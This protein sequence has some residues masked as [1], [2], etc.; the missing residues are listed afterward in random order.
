VSVA[1]E[2]SINKRKPVE[3][4]AWL[5]KDEL[6]AEGFIGQIAVGSVGILFWKCH[7]KLMGYD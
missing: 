7:S 4:R 1:L 6:R 2:D 3:V 5:N